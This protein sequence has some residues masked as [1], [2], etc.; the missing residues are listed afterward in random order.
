MFEAVAGGGYLGDIAIDDIHF[1]KGSC[2]GESFSFQN[3]SGS[4]NGGT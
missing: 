2:K 3:E 1:S 4:E